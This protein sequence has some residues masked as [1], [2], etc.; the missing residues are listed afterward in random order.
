M[1]TSQYR[2]TD[3]VDPMVGAVG[4]LKPSF[5][6]LVYG[7]G[8][9]PGGFSFSNRLDGSVKTRIKAD[10]ARDNT[11]CFDLAHPDAFRNS[12]KFDVTQ[13]T[14][15][16]FAL[17]AAA[18]SNAGHS[19]G[20]NYDVF[21]AGGVALS[22][23]RWVVVGGHDKAGN[24]GYN[25]IN[26]FDPTT[27]TWVPRPVPPV[28]TDYLADPTGLLFPHPSPLD[29]SNTEPP[30]PSDMK[31]DRWYPTAVTLPDGRVL[32]LSGSDEDASVGAALAA[33]TKV[34]Q[35]VPEVYDPKTDRTI[36]LENSRKLFAMYPRAY[37]VQTGAGK[38]DWKVAVTGEVQ[39]PLPT[40]KALQAFDPFK[41][42]GNTY[43]LD[44]LGA[45]AD[46]S[47]DVPAENH[48]Q[49]VATAV[50]PHNGGAGAALWTLD[51]S[52]RARSQKVARFGGDRGVATV[53]TI[54]FQAPQPQ[55]RRQDDLR[56]PVSENNAVVLPTGEVVI[57]GG[58]RQRVDSLHYQLFNPET[59]KI[60]PLVDTT[61]PRQDHSTVA[62]LPDGTVL[63]MG[64]NRTD[65]VP[66]N[67][68][69][70]VPVAQVYYPSYLFKGPGPVI[71]EAPENIAYGRPFDVEVSGGSRRIE[72][73]VVIRMGP[74][75]HNWDWDNR[76]VSLAFHAGRGGARE[77]RNRGENAG[78]DK[79]RD[80]NERERVVVKAPAAPGL[81]VPGYYLLFVVDEEG[82]P[83]V[84]MR[85]H[86][87]RDADD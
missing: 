2:G 87:G 14:E 26:I 55:W 22:D 58:V 53:E 86:L 16:D 45:L 71:E 46:P 59:G 50:T 35:A 19:T 7:L 12:G 66:G 83:S 31:Y 85:V 82:V 80:K 70:G 37:V 77:D 78:E 84:A 36:A 76:Y 13:L 54:D 42:N 1:R 61:V 11:L 21:C 17:N 56:D 73:V 44:V 27:Q 63:A 60:T 57:I 3:L 81:A 40:G 41:Y 15:A 28:K 72:S 23:G 75:T 32:I 25:K 69:A 33:G 29:R 20:L 4:L 9:A 18:F 79:N 49:F 39:P 51:D 34:R 43:L 5:E 6:N 47:R 67:P 38:N 52:G 65:L 48:W 74:V 8:F 62:L 64:G 10:I 24:V 30:D 68:D